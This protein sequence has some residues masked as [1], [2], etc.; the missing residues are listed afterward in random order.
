M[1][2]LSLTHTFTASDE[3]LW[4]LVAFDKL[5]DWHPLVPNIAMS[6]DGAVRTMGFGPMTAV[7]RLVEQNE[8]SYSY[9]VE[10]SPMPVKDYK[11]TW[12][13]AAA[14]GGS[15]LTIAASY[16]PKG[17]AAVAD[18]LLNAFFAAAFKALEGELA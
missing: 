11:A 13:V 2:E 5:A 15:T 16:E 9:I 12:T 7:E 8:R 17:P 14:E 1:A 3:A 10:K 4:A 6:E 18:E